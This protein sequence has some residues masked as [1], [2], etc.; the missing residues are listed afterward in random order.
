MR[1]RGALCFGLGISPAQCRSRRALPRSAFETSNLRATVPGQDSIRPRHSCDL[2]S[3]QAWL[4]VSESFSRPF[5]WAFRI[6]FSAVKYS[7]CAQLLVHRPRDIGQDARPIHNGSP[8]ADRPR[9]RSQQ[10]VPDWP[11]APL[12]TVV[13]SQPEFPA[14]FGFL[15]IRDI[16]RE[17]QPV[18]CRER[19]GGLLRYY[20]QEAA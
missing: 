20:H 1:R 8:C 17:P 13:D 9:R 18:Q 6:R 3:R 12:H 10:N 14:R 7:F 16:R 2:G 5:N 15:T 19:L 11:P 4:P